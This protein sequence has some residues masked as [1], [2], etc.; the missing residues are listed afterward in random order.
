MSASGAVLARLTRLH[1][2]LID[3]SLG[4]MER[5]L[6]RLGNPERRLPPV[7][8][9][10]GTNGKGSVTAY[11]AAIAEAAGLAAHVYTSPHLVRFNERIRVAGREL[12]DDA[13]VEVLEACERANGDDPITF[14][15]VTTAAAFLAFA[16]APADLCILEVGLGGRLDATNVIARPAVTAITPV[17]IDHVQ[18]L[19]DT[20]TAIAGEK[21]G[22]LKP[23]VPAVVGLQQPEA[24]AAIERRAAEIGAPL[25]RASVEWHCTRT[26][27]G[28]D[29]KD[30]A[31]SLSLPRPALAGEH[32]VDNAALAVAC[33]RHLAVPR[34][35]EAALAQGIRDA[36]WPA[37]L[38]RLR[39]GPLVAMLPPGWELWLDGGHNPAAGA[40]IAQY[41]ATAWTD[42]P[43]HAVVGML[44]TKDAGGFL[45]QLGRVATTVRAVPIPGVDA[46][47]PPAAIVAAARAVNVESHAC[48]SAEDA[49]AAITAD[50]GPCRILVCGSLY[51]A[52]AVLE[53]NG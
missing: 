10:A 11:L 16:Q 41:A 27:D 26:A 9:V 12:S 51:L 50:R 34:I 28:F 25:H 46:A 53:A 1:P 13:L 37:R 21:A 31:T 52:G 49:V 39:T 18:Y 8:H 48:A 42:M 6:E 35:T 24:L 5:L 7:I 22:I 19:G 30:G 29:W 4:R 2:K 33:I 14:F 17:S 3:L 36:R 47:L 20:L 44:D 15:E 32:Q 40:M 38:Q 43:T 45:A 23:G